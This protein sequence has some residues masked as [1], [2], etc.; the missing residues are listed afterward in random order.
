VAYLTG[1]EGEYFHETFARHHSNPTRANYINIYCIFMI[2]DKNAQ[3]F[4]VFIINHA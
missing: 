1:G 4:I 3:T 2:D